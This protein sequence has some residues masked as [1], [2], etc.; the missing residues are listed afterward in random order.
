MTPERWDALPPESYRKWADRYGEV[1]HIDF[2]DHLVDMIEDLNIEAIAPG[3][4][5]LPQTDPPRV[6]YGAF[7][8]L[9][10]RDEHDWSL[11]A[12]LFLP[13]H[14]LY[15][16]P[17]A[18]TLEQ[19]AGRTNWIAFETRTVAVTYDPTVRSD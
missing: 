8:F 10:P 15:P 5:E 16:R 13:D 7:S 9:P 14:M 4:P 18:A 2:P 19:I 3:L 6:P 12:G 11:R 17:F 1:R